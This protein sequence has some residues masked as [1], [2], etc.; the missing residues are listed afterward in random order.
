MDNNVDILE[1]IPQRMPIVMVD[2][3]LG[4][5]ENMSRTCLTVSDGNIF[6]DNGEFSECGLIEHIAQSAAARVG[7]IFKSQNQT[8]PIGYIGA[9]N[10]FSLVENPKVGD[11]ITTVNGSDIADINNYHAGTLP[12]TGGMGTV[13][14]TVAGIALMAIAAGLFMASRRR[15]AEEE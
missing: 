8:I 6:V 2:E 1:L 13:L 4:I 5:E 9:V 14:F 11:T 10:D 15:N 7:Y 3:F 12:S